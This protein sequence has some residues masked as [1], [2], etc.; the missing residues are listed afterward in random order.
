VGR[1]L[2]GRVW[3]GG[4]A[5]VCAVAGLMGAWGQWWYGLACWLLPYLTGFQL[6]LRI[7]NIA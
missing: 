1:G 5:G 6:V 3:W 4:V 2:K 7:R